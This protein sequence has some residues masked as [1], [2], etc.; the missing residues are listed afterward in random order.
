MRILVIG[1]NR[2]GTTLILFILMKLLKYQKIDIN[3]L[4]DDSSNKL[5]KKDFIGFPSLSKATISRHIITNDSISYTTKF[6]CIYSLK[7]LPENSIFRVNQLSKEDLELLSY[8][9]IV[10]HQRIRLDL[11]LS[12]LETYQLWNS[13]W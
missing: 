9:D 5:D 2:S 3:K 10:I 13:L 1:H 8:F 11:L 4:I 6:N 12:N 7:N